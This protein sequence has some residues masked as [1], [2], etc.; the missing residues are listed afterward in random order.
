MKDLSK[1][2]FINLFY[3][4]VD[5]NYLFKMHG[6]QKIKGI[7]INSIDKGDNFLEK[8]YDLFEDLQ[9]AF[10]IEDKSILE[11]GSG[12]GGFLLLSNLRGIKTT[13]VEP[14]QKRVLVTRSILKAF[15]LNTDLVYCTPAES[16]PFNSNSY[17]F[18]VSCQ[19]LEHVE[20]PRKVIYESIRVLKPNGL[21]YFIFP[22]YNSFY[23][24]HIGKAWAPFI[25][26]KNAK[27]YLKLLGLK[28]Y[29]L[30]NINFLKPKLIEKYLKDYRNE[31]EILSLG[32]KEFVE[33]YFS[34]KQIYK[35][36]N[37]YLAKILKLIFFI[38]ADKLMAHLL[39]WLKWYYPIVMIVKKK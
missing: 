7:S 28:E 29:K 37:K 23:E 8:A 27:Y 4:T 36:K 16:L 17:D 6:M 24:G 14:D 10:N 26:K 22:N 11:I 39:I 13:G 18:V 9:N 25:N 2:Q 21:I 31:I 3:N 30:K 20:D 19:V 12:F 32:E 1:Q 38:K 5:L 33:K 15:G 35:V 34:R